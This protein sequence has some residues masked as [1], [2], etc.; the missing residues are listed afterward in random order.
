MSRGS[1]SH[2]TVL[3]L[4]ETDRRAFFRELASARGCVD[5]NLLSVDDVIAHTPAQ[6]NC[7]HD[8]PQ[9]RH[10]TDTESQQVQQQQAEQPQVKRRRKEASNTGGVSLEQRVGNGAVVA[11]NFKIVQVLQSGVGGIDF[12]VKCIGKGHPELFSNQSYIL[13]ALNSPVNGGTHEEATEGV[14]ALFQV[15]PHPNIAQHFCQFKDTI[16]LELY[17]HFPASVTEDTVTQQHTAQQGLCQLLMTWIVFEHHPDSLRNFLLSSTTS[18]HTSPT[19]PT[20]TET[21][22]WSVV[23]KYSRDI[24]DALVHL[25]NNGIVHFNLT[26]DNIAVSSNKEQVI[27]TDLIGHTLKF[28][29]ENEPRFTKHVSELAPSC[30]KNTS[31][32]A[33]E[34]LN[35]ISSQ[36]N[37]FVNCE[38]QG[39]FGLGCIL[40]ELAM[41]VGQHPL[42]GYP[43]SFR[44]DS[45]GL[46]HFEFES[47]QPF[48]IQSPSFP[49]KFCE[50]VRGLLQFDPSKRTPLVGA[51]MSL[52]DKIS[53][54]SGAGVFQ[55]DPS[56]RTP[57]VDAHMCLLDNKSSACSGVEK[58]TTLRDG[59]SENGNAIHKLAESYYFGTGVDQDFHKAAE[60][61]QKALDCGHKASA[62]GLACCYYEGTGVEKDF[63]KAAVLYQ[64]ALD[65]GNTDAAYDLGF[66]YEHGEGVDEDTTRAAELYQMAVNAGSNEAAFFLGNCYYTGQG[67]DKDTTTAAALFQRAADAGYPEAIH[68]LGHFYYFGTGVEQDF[69]KAAMLLQKSLD[70]GNTCSAFRLG[71]CYFNGRGVDKDITRAAVLFQTAAN[72]GL[73]EACARLG[74][75][76]YSGMGVERDLHKAAIL[77]QRALDSGRG[78]AMVAY[79]LGYCYLNGDGVEK[80][81]KKAVGL[82]YSGA[83]CGDHNARYMLG[84]CYKSG[85][86][87]GSVD[88]R[89][90]AKFF[91]LAAAEGDY[92]AQKVLG[93]ICAVND[94]ND[95]SDG[96][97]DVDDDNDEDEDEDEDE[98][99]GEGED[100]K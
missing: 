71:M 82:F 26:L 76:Y 59:A 83:E 51:H 81:T 90:A 97:G 35:A 64:K 61:Y 74:D 40:F 48:P 22:P 21:T 23:H 87:V 28:D 63:H 49:K 72:K 47:E 37:S 1:C 9:S 96:D 15:D 16:P 27:L 18:L 79:D 31:H 2:N 13:K 44:N 77:Y 52:L 43:D 25:F 7:D 39:S 60:L 17:N 24:S 73:P 58:D 89:T 86:G 68:N 10:A 69:H 98:G 33:P 45:D 29:E 57:L 99:E 91:R 84:K 54:C 85:E 94:D 32:I 19:K 56:K 12:E 4:A 8:R 42:P 55:C 3:A 30:L 66:C 80:D 41:G 75:C 36:H 38:M 65:A 62:Y 14:S 70:A 5:A 6:C 67:V 53:A 88:M 11:R 46:I 50:L 34:I 78:G 92:D 95:S 93:E 100:G 20:T